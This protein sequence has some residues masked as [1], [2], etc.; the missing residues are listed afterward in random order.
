MFLRTVMRVRS[1][2]LENGTPRDSLAAVN[3]V[4][5]ELVLVRVEVFDGRPVG[6]ELQAHLIL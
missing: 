4:S 5:A 3:A 1:R 2:L 6:V